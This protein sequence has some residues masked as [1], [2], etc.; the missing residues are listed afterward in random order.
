M[1][2]NDHVHRNS[3][4]TFEA[5]YFISHAG[6]MMTCPFQTA[7]RTVTRFDF[8]NTHSGEWHTVHGAPTINSLHDSAS[9]ATDIKNGG[10]GAYT[11][12]Y[13][14]TV[15]FLDDETYEY[16]YCKTDHFYFEYQQH[17]DHNSTYDLGLTYDC[18]LY[19]HRTINYR[20]CEPN[21][22]GFIS[23]TTEDTP[24]ET[25]VGN[26]RKYFTQIE[27]D[28]HGEYT[29]LN[30]KQCPQHTSILKDKTGTEYVGG[31]REEHACFLRRLGEC[32]QSTSNYCNSGG[33]FTCADGFKFNAATGTNTINDCDPCADTK[34]CVDG[35]EDTCPLGYKCPT[36][37]YQDKNHPAQPGEIFDAG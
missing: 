11:H 13:Q 23:P 30:L 33:E 21:W 8:P 5:A 36:Y 16:P 32:E 17:D 1:D 24:T 37:S 4:C 31:D 25:P 26:D 15:W 10:N 2:C 12:E 9:G 35:I 28:E 20:Q 22:G 18:S 34:F 14:S 3:L 7:E 6:A 29:G 27:Y 19:E